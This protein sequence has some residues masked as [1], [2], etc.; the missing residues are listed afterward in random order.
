MEH[1]HQLNL[2]LT[3]AAMSTRML[4]GI[5]LIS[6]LLFVG[7]ISAQDPP[8]YQRTENIV[9]SVADGAGWLLDVFEPVSSKN[10]L[11][12]VLVLSRGWKSGEAPVEGYQKEDVVDDTH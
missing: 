7:P 5:L 8:A 3:E 6:T 9:F 1:P 11:G 2:K 12:I 4:C 10:G